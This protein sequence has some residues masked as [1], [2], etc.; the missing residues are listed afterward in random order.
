MDVRHVVG[1]LG[2]RLVG[3][4][5]ECETC[6]V[7]NVT[8]RVLVEQ[9]VEERHAELAYA[10]RAV[11]EGDLAE[12]SCTLVAVQLGPNHVR[13]F[14]G[15][16]LDHAAALETQL[17]PFHH[18]PAGQPERARRADGP[19]RPP[20]IWCDEHFFGRHVGNALPAACGL[21]PGGTPAVRRR[22]SDHQLGAGSAEAHRVE[23]ALVQL[24]RSGREMVDVLSPGGDRIRLVEPDGFHDAVP[25]TLYVRLA[26]HLLRPAFVGKGHDRPVQAP[27]VEDDL[28]RPLGELLRACLAD[29]HAVE[30]GEKVRVR[31]ARDRDLCAPHPAEVLELLELPRR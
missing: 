5:R 9:R 3:I 1:S 22:Q 16:D 12:T 19:F 18:H 10:R 8:G 4:P 28:E 20:G 2:E 25:E 24:R 27:F 31:I 13:T 26:E 11:D 14:V 29:P 7:G 23:A 15:L 17:E 21:E 30:V 6:A